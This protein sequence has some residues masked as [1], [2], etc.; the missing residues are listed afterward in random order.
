VSA[1]THG[2]Q[3]EPTASPLAASPL[4]RERVEDLLGRSKSYW[5][6]PEDRRRGLSEDMVKV[7]QFIVGGSSGHNVPRTATLVG[8][9][10]TASALGGP[11]RASAD[12]AGQTAGSRFAQGGGVAAQQGT[13]DYTGMIR[14]VNFPAFVA[15]L[16]D[17]VFNA[18][19]TSS[20][21]QMDAYAELV[22][23]VAKSV[24]DFMKDN[25][26]ENSARDYLANRYP[27]QLQVDM[28]G[29]S[30]VL[31]PKE[32][33]DD[34]SLPD[35]FKDLG[36]AQPVS[37]LDQDTAE[38]VLMPAAR[39]RMAMDRQQLLATMV[40]M[41]INRLVV[42]DGNI[43]ASCTFTL[44]TKDSV[45]RHYDSASQADRDYTYSSKG[46]LWYNPNATYDTSNTAH[47]TVSTHQSEDSAAQTALHA[48]LGGKVQV[49]FKSDVFPLEKMADALQINQI[50]QNAPAG[51]QTQLPAGS[52]APVAAPPATPAATS[53]A[54]PQG[55]GR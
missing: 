48:Q 39:Q 3:P 50:Q 14:D 53:P 38:Q 23:N 42:T 6:L 8:A 2:P 52:A 31:K 12:P 25:I 30:P 29:D 24:D 5:E 18:I 33:A 9:P 15:G 11:I 32:G 7:A 55:S 51:I 19:V 43:Q 17:G 21:K 45:N 27:D 54:T 35:F 49:N 46:Q 37:S 36:L 1:L 41:G 34:S 10:S 40:L 13:P 47:F 28:S 44:D 4:V 26:S 16:I 22:K 20:I